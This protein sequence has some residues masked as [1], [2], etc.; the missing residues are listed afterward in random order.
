MHLNEVSGGWP[1]F[2][3]WWWRG[4]LK[5]AKEVIEAISLEE[6]EIASLLITKLGEGL[7]QARS[8]LQGLS[9]QF[10]YLLGM[11]LGFGDTFY[12]LKNAF[13]CYKHL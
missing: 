4:C 5:S 13:I 9:E 3:L 12:I 6:V 1:E 8:P 2:F 11:F 10:D 7:S